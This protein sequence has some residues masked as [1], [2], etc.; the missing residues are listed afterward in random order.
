MFYQWGKNVG[1][2]ATDPLVSSNG[3]TT[4]DQSTVSGDVWTSANDPCPEG[5]QVP[6]VDDFETLAEEGKVVST[7]TEQ[8]GV[9]GSLFVD[10]ATEESIFLPAAGYRGYSSGSVYGQDTQGDYWSSTAYNDIDG[11]Y[12]YFN[13]SNGLKSN[14]NNYAFGMCIRCVRK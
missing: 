5:W 11:Y 10:A 6:S 14:S 2:S 7:W 12:L 4:W 1:W 3:D 13:S 8:G 9:S